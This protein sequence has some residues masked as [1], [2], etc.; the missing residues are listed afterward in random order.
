MNAQKKLAFLRTDFAVTF[1][2]FHGADCL[3]P[4]GGIRGSSVRSGLAYKEP[5]LQ[6]FQD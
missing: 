6:D 1:H 2:V 5:G 4:T 3:V